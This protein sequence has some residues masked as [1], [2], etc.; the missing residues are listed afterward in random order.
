MMQ[1]NGLRCHV[2]Q[3]NAM[4]CDI[5]I[6]FCENHTKEEEEGEKNSNLLSN[7]LLVLKSG[8]PKFG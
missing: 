2:M 7:P 6:M 5:M 3:C 4:Q 1:W 8:I